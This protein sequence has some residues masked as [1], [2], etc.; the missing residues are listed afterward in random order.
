MCF[1]GFT[2]LK[3]AQLFIGYVWHK[4]DTVDVQLIFIS[5]KPGADTCRTS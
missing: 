2:Q 4:T 1:N 5:T 3:W